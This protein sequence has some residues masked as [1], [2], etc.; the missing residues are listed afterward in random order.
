VTAGLRPRRVSR[1]CG[2]PRRVRGRWGRWP[3]PAR[4]AAPSRHRPAPARW[5]AAH[6]AG[7]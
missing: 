3:V 5:G 4:R 7:V 1:R 2:G 6:R